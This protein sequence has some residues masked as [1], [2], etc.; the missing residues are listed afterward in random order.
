V[1]TVLPEIARL[2]ETSLDEVPG[3]FILTTYTKP[4]ILPTMTD[5][6]ILKELFNSRFDQLELRLASMAMAFEKENDRQDEAIER[7]ADRSTH[8]NETKRLTERVIKMEAQ[9]EA[10][11]SQLNELHFKVKVTWAVGGTLVTGIMAVLVAVI[12]H[13]IGV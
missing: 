3:N 10:G 8:T 7:L 4:T 6:A 1:S 13:W 11:R 9:I 2:G 12:Q 5:L